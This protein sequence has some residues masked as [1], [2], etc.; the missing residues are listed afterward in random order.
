MAA[1]GL[2]DKLRK[3]F[4]RRYITQA[5]AKDTLKEIITA[6]QKG[7]HVVL[8]FG[9]FES[10]LDYL[11]VTNLITRRIRESW[12]KQTNEFRAQNKGEPRPLTIVLEEAHKLL[13]REMAAQTT[14]CDHCPRT[15]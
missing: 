10:D 2:H 8:S 11:L 15:A 5:P 7:R 12:E 6:L 9:D 14:F 4:D 3:V 1:Q 13:N